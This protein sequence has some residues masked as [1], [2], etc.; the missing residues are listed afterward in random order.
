M[1]KY[2]T[3]YEEVVIHI[4][5][6]NRSHLN[7]LTQCGLLAMLLYLWAWSAVP[8]SYMLLRPHSVPENPNYLPVSLSIA[9]P[10]V[11]RLAGPSVGRD[12][13]PLISQPKPIHLAEKIWLLQTAGK[14]RSVQVSESVLLLVRHRILHPAH[15]CTLQGIQNGCRVSSQKARHSRKMPVFFFRPF[16][17]LKNAGL[18]CKNCP[19][20]SN[21]TAYPGQNFYYCANQPTCR[22]ILLW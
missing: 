21:E 10:P 4:W 18:F 6:C 1:R 16:D 14:A 15:G 7:Y 5:L 19:T 13:F 20:F 3:I 11:Y 17:Q 2:L 8:E 12:L 22:S 9:S